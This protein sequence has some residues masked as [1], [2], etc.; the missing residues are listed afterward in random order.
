[1]NKGKRERLKELCEWAE[2]EEGTQKLGQISR[3]EYFE[4]SKRMHEAKAVQEKLMLLNELQR[5]SK[6][7][8]TCWTRFTRKQSNLLS[9]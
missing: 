5:I 6:N 8:R 9:H 4:V 3:D 7:L 1:M 2:V